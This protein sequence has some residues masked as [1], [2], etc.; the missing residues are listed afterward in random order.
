MKIDACVF[1]GNSLYSNSV[2]LEEILRQ[3]DKNGV[4]KAVIRPNKPEDYCY[5]RA[6]EITAEI[7][8]RYP[9][10]IGFGRINPLEKSARDQLLEIRDMGLHG[11]HIHPWEDNFA[12]NSPR[13]RDFFCAAGELGLPVYVSAGYPRVSEPLQMY[14][15][16]RTYPNVTFIATHG[17]QLDMSGMSFDDATLSARARNLYFDL[18]GIYRRDFIEKLIAAA[19]AER[20]VFG[21]CSPYMDMGFEIERIN[22]AQIPEE[23][24]RMIFGQNLLR[25]IEEK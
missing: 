19:G 20:I 17:A 5:R 4:D 8:L 14:E 18:S 2:S 7:R 23:Q 16:A 10:L 9:R 24:K 6:N 12:V 11:V 21:S 25:I 22:A 3:M 13:F 1:V 15:C